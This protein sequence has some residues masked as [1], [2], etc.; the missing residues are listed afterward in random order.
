[1][2][3]EISGVDGSGKTTQM[4]MVSRLMQEHGLHVYRRS[5]YSTGRRIL[6]NIAV[7]LG[8]N[9]WDAVFDRDAVELSK[10]VEMFQYAHSS[11]LSSGFNGEIVMVDNYIRR[12]L[13]ASLLDGAKNKEQLLQVYRALPAPDL[14]IHLECE[15][16][17]AYER[18]VARRKGDRAIRVGG[19]DLIRRFA[20]IYGPELD[21]A[22]HYKSVRLSSALPAADTAN[23]IVDR[24]RSWSAIHDPRIYKYLA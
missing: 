13:A 11:L 16:E 2:I 1:M 18:I 9:S 17:V 8:H 5:F 20:A 4:E 3:I 12:W 23:M 15:A 21:A 10:A 22:L 7:Q 24:I 14:S 19:E 6:N